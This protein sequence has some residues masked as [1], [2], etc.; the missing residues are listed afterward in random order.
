MN[1]KFIQELNRKF[2]QELNYYLQLEYEWSLCWD[3][4]LKGLQHKQSEITDQS[5]RTGSG[6]DE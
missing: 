3:Y 4:V 5:K 1:R 6:K 2:I